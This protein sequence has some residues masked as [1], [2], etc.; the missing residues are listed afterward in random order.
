MRDTWACTVVAL[1][2]RSL[3]ISALDLP[4]ATATATSRSRSL[5]CQRTVL[6]WRRLLAPVLLRWATCPEVR[7]NRGNGCPGRSRTVGGTTLVQVTFGWLG[8]LG[9]GGGFVAFSAS[10]RGKGMW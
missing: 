5:S 9:G 4:W 8:D 10:A 3:P 6:A 2:N 1:M 7:P